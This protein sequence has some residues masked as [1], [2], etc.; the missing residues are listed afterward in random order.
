M[1]NDFLHM[2]ADHALIV[3]SLDPS[4][5]CREPIAHAPEVR[6]GDHYFPPSRTHAIPHRQGALL[7]AGNT[8]D[9][10]H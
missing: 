8:Y 3:A 2:S 7:R 4:R 1:T 6:L 5:A 10:T 9:P